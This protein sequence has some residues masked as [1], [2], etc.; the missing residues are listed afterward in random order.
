MFPP[1]VG[2]IPQPWGALWGEG[3]SSLRYSSVQVL[4]VHVRQLLHLRPFLSPQITLGFWSTDISF[5]RSLHYGFT[6]G[7]SSFAIILMYSRKRRRTY[8]INGPC[9]TGS[10]LSLSCW[11][12]SAEPHSRPGAMKPQRRG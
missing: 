1:S 9:L 12:Q 2:P 8:E 3:L 5:F 4:S 7:L 11:S 10:P 6:G